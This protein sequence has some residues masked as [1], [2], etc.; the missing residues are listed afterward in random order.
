MRLTLRAS[1]KINLD[2]RIGVRRPDG[3][4]DLQ[5][6]FQTLDL[7]DSLSMQSWRGAFALDGDPALMPLDHTN[8]VWRAA[9]ALWRASGKSGDPRGVRVRVTKRI[10]ARAGLGGGSSDA[11]AA[12]IGLSQVWRLPTTLRALLPVAATLGSD[13]PFFLIGGTALGLGRGERVYP[14]VNRPRRHVV[15]VLPDFGVST[16]DAYRWLTEDRAM[17]PAPWTPD[18]APWTLD[19]APW[20]PDPAPWTPD[21]APWT[22]DPA[23]GRNDLEAVVEPRH[24][25]VAAIR[26]QLADAGAE[27]ARMSGSGS[28]VF[29]LFSA[30]LTARRAAARLARD[31]HRVVQTRTRPRSL[32]ESRRL[33]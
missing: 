6:L 13:V 26:R 32:V 23:S 9:D 19:P 16:S 29:G 21:P 28:A 17:D 3:Y 8:L 1:A 14:L 7:H 24:P 33:I 2:L 18:P 20:T 27:L 25:A 30:E 5:T 4:H 15:V 10:P 31:G 11:A 22:L 12:L